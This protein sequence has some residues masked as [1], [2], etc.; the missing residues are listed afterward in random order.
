MRAQNFSAILGSR[1]GVTR[2][3]G[4]MAITG[5]RLG[6]LLA[7]LT[8]AATV[9]AKAEDQADVQRS[10]PKLFIQ[11]Y[12]HTL[13]PLAF[14]K[15][16]MNYRSECRVGDADAKLRP[17]E[18]AAQALKDV[19]VSVNRAISPMVKSTD[20]L[21]ASWAISPAA[22]D[23]NDYA[24]TKR[25]ELINQGWPVSALRL[26]VVRTDAGQAHL[27]L[28]VRLPDGDVVLDNLSQKIE[29]WNATGYEWISMQSS[30]NPNFWVGI[31][32]QGRQQ[33]ASR[34]AATQSQL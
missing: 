14:V 24:V 23:C 9:A 5:F 16:C 7:L 8:V 17:P 32:K 6:I 26:A 22:G 18:S 34:I 2:A 33:R 10:E 27:V 31:E 30:E 15:F 1:T 28:V 13:A 19:N 12:D 25:H 3:G 29:L 11:E 4:C 20:P 21:L